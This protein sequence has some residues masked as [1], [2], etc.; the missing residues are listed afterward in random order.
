[1]PDI[2]TK[3]LVHCEA[4]YDAGLGHLVRCL[5]LADELHDRYKCN[6][7]FVIWSCESVQS[8]ISGHGYPVILLDR[9]TYL[10]NDKYYFSALLEQHYADLVIIDVADCLLPD[11]IRVS[12]NSTTKLAF[13]DD[14][15]ARRLQADYVFYPPVPQTNCLDWG[16]FEGKKYIGWQWVLLRSQFAKINHESTKGTI[17]LLVTM[18]GS[19]PDGLTMQVLKSLKSLNMNVRLTIVVGASYKEKED[20]NRVAS[21]LPF[22]VEVMVDVADMAG[23]MAQSDVAITSFGM[24]AYELAAVGVPAIYLCLTDD[25]NLSASALD[26]A[27]MGVNLGLYSEVTNDLLLHSVESL[28]GNMDARDEM[29][30]KSRSL[31]DGLGTKRISKVLMEGV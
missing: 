15:S 5:S 30:A 20:I 19:D 3:V 7:I 8:I 12:S 22:S 1:M 27:G 14:G 6:V 23:L 2:A 17:R 25:H 24:T 21:E 10:E 11:D 4:G 31:I 18:G 16:G 29:S 9:A 26:E 28:V 13:I